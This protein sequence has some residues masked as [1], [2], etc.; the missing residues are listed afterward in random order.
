MEKHGIGTS[1]PKGFKPKT[2]Q[3]SPLST[4][5][6]S[7]ITAATGVAGSRVGPQEGH[8]PTSILRNELLGKG[9]RERFS[10]NLC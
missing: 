2:C 9:K 5:Q 7:G 10:L 1:G 3:V 6:K 8:H 4:A